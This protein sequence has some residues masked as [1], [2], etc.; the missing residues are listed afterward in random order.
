MLTANV[1]NVIIFKPFIADVG[2]NVS[3]VVV[4]IVPASLLVNVNEGVLLVPDKFWVFA[5][6]IGAVVSA[7]AEIVKVGI[8]RIFDTLSVAAAS[9]T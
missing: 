6:I 4:I 3:D 5:L 2:E 9:V 7:G 8:V 1:L